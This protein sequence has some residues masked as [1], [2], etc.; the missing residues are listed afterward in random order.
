MIDTVYAHT[1]ESESVPYPSCWKP[2]RVACTDTRDHTGQSVTY[3]VKVR[4]Q[5]EDRRRDA[6]AMQVSEIIG[7]GVAAGMGLKTHRAAFVVISPEFAAQISERPGYPL[8]CGGSHFGTRWLDS[9]VDGT[10]DN[11]PAYA[12]GQDLL[13]LWVLDCWLG[14]LDRVG[15]NEGNLLFLYE[16]G[17]FAL[18]ASDHSDCFD[19]AGRFT[20][21]HLGQMQSGAGWLAEYPLVKQ[22]ILDAPGCGSLEEAIDRARFAGTQLDAILALVPEDWW[23]D[24]DLDPENVR[25]CL[26]SRANRLHEICKLEHYRNEEKGLRN[27][28][29]NGG[30]LF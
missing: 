15:N 8:V 11:I 3:Y 24:A 6:A 27:G 9:V 4:P 23:Q 17:S 1:L 20:R 14:I 5:S 10:A 29:A 25:N 18:I 13:R 28:I 2:F 30:Q 16:D 21:E 26:T 7:L 12:S 22:C 19:G